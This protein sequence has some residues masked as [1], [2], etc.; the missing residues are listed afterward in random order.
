MESATKVKQE[1]LDKRM[2]QIKASNEKLSQI[3]QTE[4]MEDEEIEEII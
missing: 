1:E 2:N 4:E 3:K